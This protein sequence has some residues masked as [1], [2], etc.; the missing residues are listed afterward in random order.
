MNF[1]YFNVTFDSALTDAQVISLCCYAAQV[2]YYPLENVWSSEGLRCKSPNS[3]MPAEIFYYSSCRR[4]RILDQILDNK[5]PVDSTKNYQNTNKKILQHN[6]N[7]IVKF[8]K[9]AYSMYRSENKERVLATS[10]EYQ[11]FILRNLR[12]DQD[13]TA[14]DSISTYYN[15]S[16]FETNLAARETSF[17]AYASKTP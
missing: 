15:P 5:S 16:T 4:L 14:Y 7:N 17:P 2:F 3:N 12:Y 11:I 9:E 8:N 6:E 1:G 10:T 13:S